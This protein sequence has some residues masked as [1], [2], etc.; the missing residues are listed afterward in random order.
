MTYQNKIKFFTNKIVIILSEK[1]LIPL[2]YAI[3]AL[4]IKR[5]NTKGRKSIRL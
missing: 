4:N 5:R 1:L 3:F 2:F